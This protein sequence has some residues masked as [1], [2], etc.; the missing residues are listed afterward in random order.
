MNFSPET[1]YDIALELFIGLGLPIRDRSA[2]M[3]DPS[4]Q[5]DAAVVQH[6]QLQEVG[7]QQRHQLSTDHSSLSTELRSASQYSGPPTFAKNAQPMVLSGPE[8]YRMT[9]SIVPY[10]SARLFDTEQSR[11]DPSSTLE[12]HLNPRKPVRFVPY[13]MP[14]PAF[15]PRVHTSDGRLES[16]SYTYQPT[17]NSEMIHPAHR[18]PPYYS[19]DPT[20]RTLFERESVDTRR[21][22]T[23]PT[24][25][26]E[27]SISDLLPPRRILP[28]P[29]L[30]AK[31][32]ELG[33]PPQVEMTSVTEEK[34]SKK[35]TAA[36][37]TRVKSKLVGGITKSIPNSSNAKST[38]GDLSKE[39]T[40]P[41]IR[42]LDQLASTTLN[43]LGNRTKIRKSSGN[44][45]YNDTHPQQG[46]AKTRSKPSTDKGKII[47]QDES[48]ITEEFAQTVDD[49]VRK[50][51]SHPAPIEPPISDL[52]EYAAMPE[53]ERLAALDAFILNLVSNDNFA[54]LCEDVEKSWRRIGLGF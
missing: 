19:N 38:K 42:K 1:G 54:V 18:T 49:F 28:F 34:V 46:A 22:A 39:S 29:Q 50:H 17:S 48:E 35:K 11:L 45:D 24:I 2:N 23:A 3:G 26:K 27:D 15:L 20:C 10:G 9:Q 40:K 53:E 30:P 32:S 47:L 51:G 6:Q 16:P 7:I 52:A 31:K 4:T 44:L 36:K 12:S 25:A 37:V 43:I 5:Q 8:D 33:V 21:P 13:L 14:S 41:T